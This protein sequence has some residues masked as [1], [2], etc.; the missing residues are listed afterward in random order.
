M[1]CLVLLVFRETLA[2][3]RGIKTEASTSHLSDV[4]KALEALAAAKRT[5]FGRVLIA[6]GTSGPAM[7]RG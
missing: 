6:E 5:L 4:S 2:V 3:L 7:S 1:S